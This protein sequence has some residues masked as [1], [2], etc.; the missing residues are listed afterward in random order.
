MDSS[1]LKVE[2]VTHREATPKELSDLENIAK[3]SNIGGV[4][5]ENKIVR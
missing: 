3:S 1:E 4:I 2:I 5:V